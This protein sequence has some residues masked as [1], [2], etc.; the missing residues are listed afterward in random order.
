MM[1]G[2]AGV[3]TAACVC[4]AL[5]FTLGLA[6]LLSVQFDFYYDLNDDTAIKDILSGAYTGSPDGHCIQMLYPLGW[7]LALIYRVIPN[8]AWYGLFLCLCQFGVIFLVTLR[9][10]MMVKGMRAVIPALACVLLFVM[11]MLFREL[12]IIQ[13]SVTAG[14]C[15]AGAT[16]LFITSSGECKPSVFFSRNLPALFLVVLAFMIRTEICMMLIPFL[17]IAGLSRWLCEEKIFT[18]ANFKK[19]F[20]LAVTAILCMT[21]AYSLDM[22]AY[23]GSEWS[24]FRS[25]F[26]ARTKLYD[27]YGIPP[28]AEHEE[29]YASIGLSRES[30]ALL[31]N[32]NFAIDS[33]IDAWRLERIALYQEQMAREGRGELKNTFGIVSKNS[34]R[35]A[36]WLYKNQIFSIFNRNFSTM[37]LAFAAVAAA[38]IFYVITCV[39]SANGKRRIVS[40]FTLASLLAA[41]SVLWLYLYMVDRLPA[42]VTT[43]LLVMELLVITGFCLGGMM[44]AEKPAKGYIVCAAVILII[45]NVMSGVNIRD[46]QREY[47]M[48]ATAD[49]RWN[50]LM[51]YCRKK[52]NN[53]YIIDVYSSTSYQGAPYSEK[54]FTKRGLCADNRYKNFDICGGW[55]AKSPLARQKLA[56]SGLNGIQGALVGA[57]DTKGAKTYFVAGVDKELGWLA[58]YYK[59][60]RTE[61][62]PE[63][64]EKIMTPS[65]EEVFNI[66]E[67]KTA[68]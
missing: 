36:L 12:V 46:V 7:C 47:V 17:L 55:S 64:V 61:V 10:F 52:G 57:R 43:P 39:L 33:S 16:F 18:A 11:G 54:I 41:R 45:F 3:K 38:Y 49:E 1:N 27:F 63:C 8:V 48:R 56:K 29:F 22:M 59:M 58:A 37:T 40:I 51:D 5:V 65:G 42:R 2:R 19:Y 31:E 34:V 24:S 62:K 44:S 4:G 30:H 15:M 50:A 60:R 32:Y 67:L 21:A 53:Y 9:L 28:Y 14:I 68:K 23:R 25:F 66:Y 26:D 20:V 6:L 13:Y 35:E